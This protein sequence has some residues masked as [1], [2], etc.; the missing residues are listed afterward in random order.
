MGS[1]VSTGT[2]RGRTAEY[3]ESAENRLTPVAPADWADIE[4]LRGIA[5]TGTVRGAAKAVRIKQSAAKRQLDRLTRRIGVPLT[6]GDPDNLRLT[7][8]GA[9]LLANGRRFLRE[10]SSTVRKI[11]GEPDSSDTSQPALR[12]ATVSD[13]WEEFIDDLATSLPIVLPTIFTVGPK[14]C[15]ELFDQFNVDSIYIWQPSTCETRLARPSVTYPVITEQLWIGLP[16]WHPCA[17]QPV[18]QLRDLQSD[19]WIVGRGIWRDMLVE[20]CGRV[21]YEPRIEQVTESDSMTR[22]LLWHGKGIA[23]LPPLLVRPGADARFVMR[24]VQDGPHRDYVLTTDPAVVPDRLAALLRQWLRAN[25]HKRARRLNPEYA[26]TLGERLT[27]AEPEV[28]VAELVSAL[29]RMTS[30]TR[31]PSRSVEPED[32]TTLRVISERGSLNR[33]AP[34]LLISQPALT[35][36]LVHLERR[37]GMKL[38]VRGNRGTALTANARRLLDAVTDAENAFASAMRPLLEPAELVSSCRTPGA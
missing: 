1:V 11:I 30:P 3:P 22:S 10:L 36:R 31:K 4:L 34:A 25:Y 26:A 9:G 12:L 18:V 24:P 21:G 16:S 17:H 27:G 5:T 29:S 7:A 14:E 15:H 20:A 38:L 37:L 19:Q 32:V 35:R 23:L 8:A 13:D 6:S 28:D 33:A 2:N